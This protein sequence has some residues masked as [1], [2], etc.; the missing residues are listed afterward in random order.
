MTTRM[1]RAGKYLV[2]GSPRSGFSLLISIINNLL[3]Q[4]APHLAKQNTLE[5][6]VY[7]KVI[8]LA[9]RYTTQ[10]YRETFARFGISRD[11]VFNG[12]FHIL[13]GGPKWLH[14]EHPTRACIRKYFGIRGKGD[15]LLVTSH[16]RRVLEYDRVVHSHTAPQLWLREEYYSSFRKF[17]SIRN[18]LG[19]I[20]SAC[21]SLNA[22]ASQYIQTFLPGESEDDIR[23]R[24][25]LYKLTDPEFFRGLVRFLKASLEDYLPCH[26]Q[27]SIMRWEDL[28]T[29]PAKTIQA[30]ASE[31]QLECSEAEASAIWAPMDHINLLRYHKHNYRKGKGIVGD[32]KNSLVN[33]HMEIFREYGFDQDLERLGYPPIPKLDP[34][35]YT[36]YQRLVAAHIRRG[37]IYRDTGDP[38]LFGFAFNKSNIDASRFAFKSFP[39]RQWTKVERSSIPEDD[40]VLAVSDTAEDC[41]EKINAILNDVVQVPIATQGD[42]QLTLRRIR[43]SWDAMVR[44]LDDPCGISLSEQFELPGRAIP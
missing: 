3:S 10:R 34:R 36:P 20:N 13:T 23:Q 32:W 18:P 27:Y 4:K 31:L 9:G 14:P 39:E 26:G 44:E 37:E 29:S 19:I 38:D 40:L 25:G 42:V 15:F 12:E 35:S 21:F 11:L 16:P 33:E 5:D 43:P 17:T 41:C 2:V 22:M 8:D 28:I 30:I 7:Q 1:S 6:A 24:H